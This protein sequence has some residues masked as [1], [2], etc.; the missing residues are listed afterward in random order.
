MPQK[1]GLAAISTEDALVEVID[2]LRGEND[3]DDDEDNVGSMSMREMMKEALRELRAVKATPGMQS[4][5]H[6]F[7][8]R[9]KLTKPSTCGVCPVMYD[10]KSTKHTPG[11]AFCACIKCNVYVCGFDCLNFHMNTGKGKAA[12]KQIERVPE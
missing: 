12:S 1:R 4:E 7:V 3:D 10:L 8:A 11:F 5:R 2:E 6:E 9:A